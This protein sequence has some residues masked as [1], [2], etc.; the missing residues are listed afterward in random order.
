MAH[1][2]G[3]EAAAGNAAM[4]TYSFELRPEDFAAASMLHYGGWRGVFKLYAVQALGTTAIV[5]GM[6]MLIT[7]NG[8]LAG[9]LGAGTWI[10][11]CAAGLDGWRRQ[12]R[13][14]RLRARLPWLFVDRQIALDDE[15]LH[16]SSDQQRLFHAW[17]LVTSVVVA[18]NVVTF[19]TASGLFIVLPTR[20]IDDRRPLMDVIRAHFHGP[21]KVLSCTCGY[22]IDPGVGA[23]CPECGETYAPETAVR[24][25]PLNLLAPEYHKPLWCAVALQVPTLL[26]ASLLLDGNVFLARLAIASLAFWVAATMWVLV[27]KQPSLLERVAMAVGPVWVLLLTMAA[28]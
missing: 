16:S 27:R 20:A 5:A 22:P 9:A 18:P 19:V 13:P 4:T 26:F 1:A 23:R 3:D 8:L 17:P 6:C 11:Y 12:N 24:G 28:S 21:L 10:C 7:D 25:T 2:V 15:G 14:E